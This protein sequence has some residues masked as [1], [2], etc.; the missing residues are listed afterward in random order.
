MKWKKTLVLVML[1]SVWGGTMM[2]ADSVSQKV[3]VIVNGSELRESG[4]LM[5][6]NTYLPLRQIADTLQSL[7]IWDEASKKV[8]LNKPNIHM[9]TFNDKAIPF[10]V[11][12]K[13]SEAKFSVY[14]EVDSLSASIE[15][16]KFSIVDPYGREKTI[17]TEEISP[18]KDYFAF[19]TK[20]IKYDFDATGSY[21]IRMHMKPS[22]SDS[23]SIVS[24]KL[25]ISESRK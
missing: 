8:T 23:W 14:A 16:F 21:A 25:I 1:L 12:I 22:G 11:V 5:D 15:A 10:G 20:E 19:R 4:V 2:F 13:G 3:R 6:G 17:Q 7:I 9:F 18:K 24:E